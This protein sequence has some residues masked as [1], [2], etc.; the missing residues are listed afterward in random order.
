MRSGLGIVRT[1][2]GCFRKSGKQ[3]SS[4]IGNLKER[5]RARQ[6]GDKIWPTI[7]R[8]HI[9]TVQ[10][11]TPRNLPNFLNIPRLCFCRFTQLC[12]LFLSRRRRLL[13]TKS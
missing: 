6:D 12:F 4:G 3:R 1:R 9:R 7:K 2:A 11:R 13:V 8:Y 10:V 5:G